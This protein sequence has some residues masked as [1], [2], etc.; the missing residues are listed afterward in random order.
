MKKLEKWL[1]LFGFGA[2][3]ALC[4]CLALSAPTGPVDPKTGHYPTW[5]NTIG[6]YVGG[7]VLFL[8]VMLLIM[9]WLLADR[10]HEREMWARV[11]EGRTP[12]PQSQIRALPVSVSPQVRRLVED[13]LMLNARLIEQEGRAYA[14][15]PN[16][17]KIQVSPVVEAAWRE[18]S[19][20]TTAIVPRGRE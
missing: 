19:P 10:R 6:P 15:L 7:G 8:V 3:T 18:I 14:E 20:D 16:G 9:R 17:P 1:L 5:L 11:A 4:L 12:T 2:M 13:Y